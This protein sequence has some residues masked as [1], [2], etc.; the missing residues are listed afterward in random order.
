MIQFW[1]DTLYNTYWA[2]TLGQLELL[3]V[4]LT[5]INVAL[6]ARN[7]TWNYLFGIPAV[8]LFGYVF[9][10]V[11]LYADVGLQWLFYLPVQA[12]GWWMWMKQDRKSVTQEGTIFAFETASRTA[13]VIAVAASSALMGFLLSTYTDAAFPY[14]DSFIMCASI[15]AQLLLL[16]R[17]WDSWMLWISVDVVGIFVYWNK[18]LYATSLLYVGLLALATYGLVNW[19]R[20]LPDEKEQ[21]YV[22]PVE[23]LRSI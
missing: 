6:I 11:N 8:A 10:Q 14:A 18:D 2:T 22:L 23:G 15:I 13:M 5:V 3:A 19:A 4:V 17:I 12:I 7:S 20:K 1:I 9:L 21:N 16:R